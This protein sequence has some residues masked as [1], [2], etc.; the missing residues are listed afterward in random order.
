MFQD[1]SVFQGK[2]LAPRFSLIANQTLKHH[3]LKYANTYS[4]VGQ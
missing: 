3:S 4:L 2:I 1:L